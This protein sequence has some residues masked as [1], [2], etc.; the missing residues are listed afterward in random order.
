MQTL[1]YHI[2]PLLADPA[3]VQ[4][5]SLL[6]ALPD[7]AAMLPQFRHLA[8]AE[9]PGVSMEQNDSIIFENLSIQQK[10]VAPLAKLRKRHLLQW[11]QLQQP[12][13][14]ITTEPEAVFPPALVQTM[15]IAS[16][17]QL[18]NVASPRS[19]F[20]GV[21]KKQDPIPDWTAASSIVVPT[22]ADKAALAARYYFLND[23]IDV[24]FPALQEPLETPGWSEQ[25]QV[26]LRYSG[27][28]DYFLFAG[29][30]SEERELITMLKSYSLLKKWLM[31]G[32][33]LL[34]AGAS[35][36]Y[37]PT[38]EKLLETYKYRGDVTIYPDLAE[39]ELKELV[40][41]AY[42]LLF[43]TGPDGRA[44]T[45]GEAWPVEWAF[46]AGVPVL[47]TDSPALTE[48]T[49][50]AALLSAHGDIDQQAHALM[51]VYKDENLRN[52][53]ISKGFERARQINRTQTL[54]DYAA[55]VRNFCG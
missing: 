20:S 19:F 16:A 35:T 27:G 44:V 23:K 11:L 5:L 31:T 42:A 6:A 14:W 50:G 45:S 18:L 38:L 47:G 39:E 24:V 32:M 34:L 29:P 12:R 3:A 41:G 9:M 55:V 49:A 40:G 15:L 8:L 26:K 36:D 37:T 25:E 2:D 54:E 28:R 10:S 53:L 48:L 43:P 51:M 21:F 1:V 22:L 46:S 30:L 13:L 33:P 17:A 4:D 7:L 52:G